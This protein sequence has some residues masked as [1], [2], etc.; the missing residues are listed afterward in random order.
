MAFLP[1][2]F[3]RVRVL[4]SKHIC[5]SSES[6]SAVVAPAAAHPDTMHS[7]AEESKE[8][9]FLISMGGSHQVLR[10]NVD[11]VRSRG[12]DGSLKGSDGYFVCFP[13]AFEVPLDRNAPNPVPL[14]TS[15]RSEER[16]GRVGPSSASPRK[17]AFEISLETKRPQY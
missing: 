11:V 7:E 5:S 10:R 15:G 4:A 9:M 16:G 8:G 12:P 1:F 14:S 13:C 6:M 2:I 17:A 3:C